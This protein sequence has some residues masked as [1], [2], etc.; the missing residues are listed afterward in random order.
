MYMC[1][2]LVDKEESLIRNTSVSEAYIEEVKEDRMSKM[3]VN[4]VSVCYY[5][6]VFGK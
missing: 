5:R 1:G 2:L 4:D 6:V 3:I